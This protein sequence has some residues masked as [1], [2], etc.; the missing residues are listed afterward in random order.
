ML[1]S[2]KLTLRTGV[3]TIENTATGKLY[4]GSAAISFSKRWNVHRCLLRKGLHHSKHLQAAWNMHGEEAFVF[5]ILVETDPEY[6][7]HEEQFWINTLCTY[8]RTYGY[9]A[10]P[11]ATSMRGFKHSPEVV[12]EIRRRNA[13]WKPT[14]DMIR[15]SI[16]GRAGFKHTPE[17]KQLMSAARKSHAMPWTQSSRDKLAATMRQISP[18][19]RWA[20]ENLSHPCIATN[21][22]T[23][24]VVRYA[25]TADAVKAG[26]TSGAVSR[27]LRRTKDYP[28]GVHKG[29]R[30]SYADK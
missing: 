30:W 29:A 6:A 17:S 10:A 2:K 20:K 24:E 7:V 1:L 9:N 21:L 16:A 19:P 13:L 11:T 27:A 15:R 22:V 26:Y 12:A 5:S 4:V 3:Y 23:G 25:S 28:N 14:P 18:L 8:D